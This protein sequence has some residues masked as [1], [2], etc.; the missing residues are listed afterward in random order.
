MRLYLSSMGF[1]NHPEKIALLVGNGRRAAVICNAMDY[2]DTEERFSIVKHEITGLV[3]LGFMPQEIDLRNYFGKSEELKHVLMAY[4]FLWVS[5]GNTF[6]LRRAFKQSGLDAL[7]PELLAHDQIVYGGYSAGACILSPSLKG[8]DLVDPADEVVV[9]YD[10]KIIWDGLHV[11]DYAI[12]P[13]Y[14]SGLY[15]DYI[16]GIVQYFVD[17]HMHFKTLRDGEVII[18]DGEQE[19]FV[20]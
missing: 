12:A 16:D 14:K 9:G 20:S 3:M 11:I 1:G 4:D 10:K 15:S 13:H 17:H 8:I 2:Q 18:I 19:S 6:L 7:L 5:G